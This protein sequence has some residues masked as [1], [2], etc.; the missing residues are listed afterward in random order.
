[1]SIKNPPS[2]RAAI[3]EGFIVTVIWASS[4]VLVKIALK[5]MGPLTIA[6][7]RYLLGF[8][9]LLPIM[10]FDK[11]NRFNIPAKLWTRMILI[12]IS[13]YLIGNGANFWALKYIPVTTGSLIMSVMP[14]LVLVASVVWLKEVPTPWQ[15]IGVVIS[16]IGSALFFGEGL[17]PGEPIG[18]AI[19]LF[20]MIGFSFFGILSRET[21]HSWGMDTLQL[22]TFPLG[23]GGLLLLFIALPLEGLPSFNLQ[24]WLVVLWL[25][26]VNTSIAYFLY[27]HS[28]Q[29]LTALEMNI[30][31]NLAPLETAFFAWI[32]LGEG[33][34]GVQ[35]LGMIVV[36]VGTFIVQ[37]T[38]KKTR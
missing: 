25:A 8:L 31:L 27:N 4:F 15:I 28:L 14:L 21:A 34:S 36:V 19:M 29:T 12:G 20:G 24:T 1:L 11:K 35:I 13:A 30:L 6:G 33:V 26:V 2:R 32:L 5:H 7:A 22:T 38:G 3:I 23:I 18:L 17:A 10:V 9:F 37:F 16:I